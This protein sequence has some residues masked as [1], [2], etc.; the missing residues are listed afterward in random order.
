MNHISDISLIGELINHAFSRARQAWEKKDL[1]AYQ[2]LARLQADLGARALDVN[3]D[4]TAKLDI[5]LGEILDFLPRLIP[6]LQ[7][8]TALPLVIDSPNLEYYQAAL[9]AYDTGKSGA[10]FLN[11]IAVSRKNLD[12]VIALAGRHK[13][14]VVVMLS[15]GLKTD[16]ST[17]ANLEPEELLETALYFAARLR[18]AGLP[19][20]F[21]YFDPGLAPVAADT[22]GI[23][24]VGT[25]AM[26]LIKKNKDL[27]GSHLIVGLSNFSF[28]LPPAVRHDVECAYVTL[29]REQGLDTIIA[30]PE[31]EWNLLPA[32]H[33]A[34]VTLR[35]AIAASRPQP[36][37][38]R[39]DCGFAQTMKIME[40]YN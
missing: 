28:G 37:Q 18:K 24:R 15:E 13:T 19:N 4:R 1:A 10:P 34:L 30:N 20:D 14:R 22:Y 9:E 3:L 8:V 35:D 6:A 23:V 11:S 2:H 17:G 27:A 39:A 5:S 25:E 32:G 36:G 31:K 29:A 26:P 16:G 33:R 12:V 21:L 40:L 7:E 38:S